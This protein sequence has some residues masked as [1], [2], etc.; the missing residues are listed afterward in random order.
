MK[1]TSE[2]SGWA[3][4]AAGDDPERIAFLN[5]IDPVL[6]AKRSREAR[7]AK[8]D[9]AVAQA[10]THATLAAHLRLCAPCH[11]A[12]EVHVHLIAR[13]AHYGLRRCP[14]RDTVGNALVRL[15][16]LPSQSSE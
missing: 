13:H 7:T 4:E 2:S 11:W 6:A 12:T 15:G 14:T 1:T 10:L 8:I 16:V 9:A 5:R 3:N